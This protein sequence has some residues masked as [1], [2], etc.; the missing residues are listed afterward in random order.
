MIFLKFVIML[1]EKNSKWLKLND[2]EDLNALRDSLLEAYH[3]EERN[4]K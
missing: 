1:L 3:F 4:K 2:H